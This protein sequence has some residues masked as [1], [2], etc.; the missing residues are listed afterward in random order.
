MSRTLAPT[1]AL[2]LQAPF[3]IG[4]HPQQEDYWRF[5][6]AGLRWLI[7][8]AG[9]RCER[10]EAAYGAGTGAQR[11]AVELLAGLVARLAPPLYPMSKGALSIVLYPLRWLDGWLQG[12]T[13]RHRIPGGYYGVGRKPG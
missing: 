2:Y 1:G 12:G 7:E 9:L 4:Y 11:I 10:V 13:Q 8:Q 5:S 3:I 6:H